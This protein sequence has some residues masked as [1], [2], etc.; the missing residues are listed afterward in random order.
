MYD[1][2]AKDKRKTGSTGSEAQEV[3][4]DKDHQRWI[5]NTG[6]QEVRQN[7]IN[8]DTICEI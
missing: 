7:Y 8:L 5:K 1:D 2:Q 4:Q 6:E 3:T